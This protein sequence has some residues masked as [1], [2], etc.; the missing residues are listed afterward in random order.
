VV[1]EFTVIV[2]TETLGLSYI[3]EANQDRHKIMQSLAWHRYTANDIAAYL[4]KLGYKT[5]R[6]RDYYP[7]LDGSTLSKLRKRKART[8]N[9]RV[10]VSEATYCLKPPKPAAIGFV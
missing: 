3:P 5:P 7:Q 10:T 2:E 4:T 6:G 1:C 9:T 8:R